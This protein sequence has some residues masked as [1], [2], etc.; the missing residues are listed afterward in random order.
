M[1]SSY[2]HSSLGCF[3]QRICLFTDTP[4]LYSVFVASTVWSSLDESENFDQTYVANFAKDLVRPG[5]SE[6]VRQEVDKKLLEYLENL[7]LQV[8]QKQALA[9]EEAGKKK[10]KA[11]K[12]KKKKGKKGKKKGK[13]GKKGKKEKKT[14]GEKACANMS[15]EDMVSQLVLLQ[16]LQKLPRRIKDIRQFIGEPWARME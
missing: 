8:E 7:K 5:V 6:K 15:F 1:F 4:H 9:D 12:S 10:K 16:I 11:K 2:Y 13:K 3:H 14:E